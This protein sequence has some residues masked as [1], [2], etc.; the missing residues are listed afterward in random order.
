MSSKR[1]NNNIVYTNYSPYENSGKILDYLKDNFSYVFHFSIGFHNLTNKR[2]SSK[3]IIFKDGQLIESH[4]LFQLTI[5]QSLNFLLLPLRSIVNFVVIVGQ[6][7]SLKIKY[8]QIDYYFT[9]NA[10]IAWIGLILRRL[11][12]V[13]KTIFWVWDYYPPVH[14]SKV[15]MLMR[16][17][18]WQ[19]D[20][21]SS[22]S[23]RVV[24]VNTRLLSLRKDL[25]VYGPDA[26]FPIVRIGTDYFPYTPR[27]KP[28]NIKYGFIGVLK[29]DQGP[30]VVFDYS[31]L[32]FKSFKNFTYDIIGSGPDEDYLKSQAQKTGVKAKFYGYLEG[33]SFNQVLQKC[34]IG[35]ATYIPDP[36]HVSH[37]G[38]PGK[39]KRYIC[40]GLPI[41]ST[42]VLEFSQEVEKAKAGIIID[43]NDPEAFVK[44]TR[45]IMSNYSFYSRNAYKLSQKYYYKKIYPEIFDFG[46]EAK[47][48]QIIPNI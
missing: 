33:E 4:E 25:G 11:K 26:K 6:I 12:I 34:T 15:V 19:F 5:P 36:S 9:V 48:Q 44:A 37:Y 38:D 35:I 29:K 46:T 17:I 28:T 1:S 32:L 23:D 45:K 47:Q 43:H 8:D 14:P 18:Y 22:Y 20:R 27:K 30:G 42:N 13:K 24:F 39:I 40:L 10:F 21:A 3:L 41:I 31:P 2:N 7:I 16:Y